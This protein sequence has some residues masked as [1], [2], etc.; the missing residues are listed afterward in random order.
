M[1]SFNNSEYFFSGGYK[2]PEK[3]PQYNILKKHIE[4]AIQ[5]IFLD[6][7]REQT[8]DFLY[9]FDSENQID[10]FV[11]RTLSYWE[12]LEKYEICKEVLDL[13]QK[14]KEKWRDRD[15]L[16]PSEGVIRIKDIFG[17]NF[18]Q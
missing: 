15:K 8:I 10:S 4:R 18:E 12:D 11:K 2:E 14:L 7:L 6:S 1:E 17:I 16:D 3:H 13:S 9:I 5:D